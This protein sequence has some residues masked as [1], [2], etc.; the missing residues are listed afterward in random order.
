[1]DNEKMGAFIAQLRKEKGM[2]QRELAAKL[3]ITDKAVSKWERCLSLPDITLLTP[4]AQE[5]GV[6]VGELLDGERE[7]GGRDDIENTLDYADKAIKSKIRSFR[8]IAAIV[9]SAALLLGVIVCGICD[10]AASGSFTW[11]LFPVSSAVFSWVLFF[12]FIKLGAKGIPVSLAS[13]TVFTVPFLAVIGALAGS[14]VLTVGIPVSVAGIIYLWSVFALF[15]VIKR[16]RLL[17]AAT[18]LLLVIPVCL[19]IN[20]I[21]AQRFAQPFLDVWDWLTF[22]V[23]AAGAAVFFV[24]DLNRKGKIHDKNIA[25]RGR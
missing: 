12:P 10:L 11:S 3:N 19:V 23:I 14:D 21:I 20:L 22:G 7:K 25:G 24:I 5:L 18:S 6:S 16:R 8:S 17:A 1:M 2:T 9:F 15:K 13:L 4:L